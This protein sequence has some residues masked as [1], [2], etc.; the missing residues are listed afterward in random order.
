MTVPNNQLVD[1]NWQTND[2]YIQHF[3]QFDSTSKEHYDGMKQQQ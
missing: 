1:I 3:D 2:K